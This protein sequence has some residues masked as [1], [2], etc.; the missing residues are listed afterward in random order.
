MAIT[1]ISEVEKS[2]GIESGKLTEMITAQE[3]FE[4]DLTNKVILE[5]S[6]YDERVA[7][8]KKDTI[9]HTQEVLIKDLRNDFELDFQ[10][11]T[12]ENLIEAFKTKIEKAKEESVKDPEQRYLTLKTDFEKLQQNL[13]EKDKEIQRIQ[14]ET[15]EKELFSVPLHCQI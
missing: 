11:K 2:L 15:V 1:N 9:Q 12:K 13:S 5:K 3:E 4:L 10:G 6:V 14:T 7:N 8:I